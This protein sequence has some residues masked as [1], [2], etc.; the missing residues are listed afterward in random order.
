[1]TVHPS[2]LILVVEDDPSMRDLLRMILEKNE[3]RVLESEDGEQALSLVQERPEI[4]LVIS[5]I[6]I[7]GKDGM[8]LLSEVVASYPGVKV[9]L[10]TAFG[11]VEQYL[12]AMNVGA[13]EYLNKPFRNQQLLDLVKSALKS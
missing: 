9:I 1:M 8:N 4:R 10:I 7:P 6:K 13:F 11:E 5:D 12:E 2:P 3:Y